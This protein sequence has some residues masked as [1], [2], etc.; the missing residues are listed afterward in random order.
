MYFNFETFARD[1]LFIFPIFLLHTICC[2]TKLSFYL[3]SALLCSP[4]LLFLFC[5]FISSQRDIEKEFLLC[6][7]HRGKN[8]HKTLFESRK[9]SH[10][11]HLTANF[12]S[13]FL[14]WRRNKFS[15]KLKNFSFWKVFHR[16][17]ANE[18]KLFPIFIS[19]V[20][21]VKFHK[22][23]RKAADPKV[24]GNVRFSYY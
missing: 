21:P 22:L 17:S 19:F 9:K 14:R 24:R 23:P 1:N 11:F 3:F 4:R 16:K 8:Y 7:H 5:C 10:I 12:A 13:S 20:R 18:E 6:R 15:R 2:F